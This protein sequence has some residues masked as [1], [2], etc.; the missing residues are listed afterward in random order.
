ME[1]QYSPESTIPPQMG[2]DMLSTENLT[3]FRDELYNGGVL[4]CYHQRCHRELAAE[5]TK[6]NL[7][8][9]GGP[10]TAPVSPH[11]PTPASPPVNG[12]FTAVTAQ[13]YAKSIIEKL[14]K[15]SVQDKRLVRDFVNGEFALVMQLRALFNRVFRVMSVIY[16]QSTLET[17]SDI[18]RP[19]RAILL[20]HQ[21]KRSDSDARG[22]ICRKAFVIV[23]DLIDHCSSKR[24]ILEYLGVLY[25]STGRELLRLAQSYRSWYPNLLVTLFQRVEDKLTEAMNANNCQLSDSLK[26]LDESL[27]RSIIQLHERTLLLGVQKLQTRCLKGLETVWACY[28]D[29]QQEDIDRFGELWEWMAGR[30]LQLKFGKGDVTYPF[31]EQDLGSQQKDLRHAII[32]PS[33]YVAYDGEEDLGQDIGQGLP[34]SGFSIRRVGPGEVLSYRHFP[35]FRHAMLCIGKK[36][37]IE[38]IDLTAD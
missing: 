29:E 22:F 27:C 37:E 31:P 28:R 32:V 6:S 1:D 2:Y 8:R 13:V 30:K 21:R 18:A 36:P 7:P 10:Q 12:N 19:Y 5:R 26:L 25:Y 17:H 24:S 35:E 14:S 15:E 11:A 16:E 3:K 38:I 20:A 23:Y 9:C 4:E 34:P 33:G